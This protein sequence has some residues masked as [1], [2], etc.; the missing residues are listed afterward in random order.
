MGGRGGRGGGEGLYM[1]GQ[2]QQSRPPQKIVIPGQKPT[3]GGNGQKLVIADK[4]PVFAGGVL[5]EEDT[6]TT[7]TGPGSYRPPAGFMNEDGPTED[8]TANMTPDQMLQ[9]LRARAGQWHDLAKFFIALYKQQY[10]TNIIDEMA[11]ITPAEQN[12]WAVA[13]TVYDSIKSDGKV[14]PEVRR[15]GHPLHAST[16]HANPSPTGVRMRVW[17]RIHT[18]MHT[19]VRLLQGCYYCAALCMVYGNPMLGTRVLAYNTA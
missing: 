6:I 2:P 8:L 18:R 13:S 15:M 7:L 4:I 11:G 17:P 9:R 19:C 16:H 3:S 14:S 5:T 1:P 12:K 10:D